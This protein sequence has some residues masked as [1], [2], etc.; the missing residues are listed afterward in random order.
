MSTIAAATKDFLSIFFLN[1]SKNCILVINNAFPSKYNQ[2]DSSMQETEVSSLTFMGDIMTNEKAIKALRQIKTYC[3][4]TLLDELDYVLL[5]MEK[6]E[7]DGIKNP[8]ETD[9]TALNQ[10]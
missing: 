2:S 6:L 1:F 3:S 9:F 4:A 5:V 7:K 10:K 8:L